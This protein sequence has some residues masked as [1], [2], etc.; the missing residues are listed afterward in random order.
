MKSSSL[1]VTR[2]GRRG[3][4]ASFP[5]S[6]HY[7]TCLVV[8]GKTPRARLP[9][10]DMTGHS[11]SE[12]C[13]F[14]EG[15]VKNVQRRLFNFTAAWYGRQTT[16]SSQSL[17]KSEVHRSFEK[18]RHS[19]GSLMI[20]GHV[21]TRGCGHA[22]EIAEQALHCSS[23]K[24]PEALSAGSAGS[25]RG[26]SHLAA[27]RHGTTRVQSPQ[28]RREAYWLRPLKMSLSSY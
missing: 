19:P 14:F 24:N 15:T 7:L 20:G 10:F 22:Q 11:S 2:G 16:G 3:L 25:G 1:A 27:W 26:V 28:Q 17:R 12:K 23:W 21:H 5:E 13:C 8:P 9:L 18:L 6:R 4:K